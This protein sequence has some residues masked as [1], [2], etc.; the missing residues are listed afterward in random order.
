MDGSTVSWDPKN[1]SEKYG[2]QEIEVI[3]CKDNS[4]HASTAKEFFGSYESDEKLA[5]YC[6]KLSTSN[7]I[8]IK[9]SYHLYIIIIKY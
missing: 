4:K 1:F 2:E 3:D 9:V 7:V 5:A 8:K 6:D